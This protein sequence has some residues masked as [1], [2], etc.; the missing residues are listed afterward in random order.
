[1]AWEIDGKGNVLRHKFTVSATYDGDTET[2]EKEFYDYADGWD[3]ARRVK[4][5]LEDEPEAYDAISIDV[6]STWV[7]EEEI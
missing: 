1:M 6:D 2:I 5:E 4:C 7:P 3:W